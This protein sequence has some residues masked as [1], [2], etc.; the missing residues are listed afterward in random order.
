MLVALVSGGLLASAHH[1]FYDSLQGETVPS[2]RSS[3]GLGLSKQQMNIA[4]GTAFAFAVKTCLVVATSTA[5]VQLFWVRVVTSSGDLRLKN[6]NA[7]YS[8]NGNVFRLFYLPGWRRFPI[9]FALAFVAWLIPIASITTPATL[10]IKIKAIIP[11]PSQMMKV[12]GARFDVF[13]YMSPMI[14]DFRS[15]PPSFYEYYG[16]SQALRRLVTAV[17]TQGSVLP[18]DSPGINASYTST[19]S[20]PSLRCEELAEDEQQVIQGNLADYISNNDC[21]GATAY[22]V[23]FGRLPYVTPQPG[24]LNAST[25]SDPSDL[26]PTKQSLGLM[27]PAAAGFRVAVLPRMLAMSKGVSGTL[28]EPL[29]CTRKRRGDLRRSTRKQSNPLG[30]LA[31]N[32]TML[33]CQLYNSTYD[34]DF[35]FTN[36]TQAVRADIRP[37]VGDQPVAAL[38]GIY[39]PDET[40]CTGMSSEEAKSKCEYPLEPVRQLS[41]LAML[42][43]LLGVIGGTVGIY[44]AKLDVNSFVTR[45]TLVDTLELRFMS[46]YAFQVNDEDHKPFMQVTL[47]DYGRPDIA[48]LIDPT[49][50]GTSKSLID[51][52]EQMFQNITISLLS[53]PLFRHD[54][55]SQEAPSTKVSYDTYHNVYIYTPYKLWLSYGAALAAATITVAIGL[56]VVISQGASYSNDFST[57]L[58]VARHALLEPEI[59]AADDGRDPLT[60]SL[61]EGFCCVR[62]EAPKEVVG[63]MN[64]AGSFQEG[65]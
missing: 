18:I 17:S 3:L 42:D 48:G 21:Y 37:I 35:D 50:S 49:M 62:A 46:E 41:Y 8:V 39:G 59:D 43:S 40:N 25:A 27:A 13:S 51:G 56:C 22:R 15:A 55:T 4:I 61:A 9:L 31:V 53:S 54:S 65:S 6:I 30:D 2:G 36:G 26:A 5:C 33:Q 57:V 16:P 60:R 11:T 52:I 47:N 34:V 38:R 44:Q 45:T 63:L 14:S 64:R 10:G 23:W 28:I 19:F 58:R 24:N 7:A 20:A 29:A 12:S 32:S 1:L